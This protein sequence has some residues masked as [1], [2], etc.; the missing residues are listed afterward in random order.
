[1]SS[2]AAGAC[3]IFWPRSGGVFLEEELFLDIENQLLLSFSRAGGGGSAAALLLLSSSGRELE[4]SLLAYFVTKATACC[5]AGPSM[6]GVTT[7][8]TTGSFLMR[9]RSDGMKFPKRFRI[10]NS[11]IITPSRARPLRT[12]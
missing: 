2:S 10:P 5:T 6:T 11:S 9:L 8:P 1:M 7:G 4:S 3:A 12:K